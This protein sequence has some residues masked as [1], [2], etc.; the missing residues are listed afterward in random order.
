MSVQQDTLSQIQDSLRGVDTSDLPANA[1]KFFACTQAQV[2]TTTAVAVKAAVTGKRHWIT[3]VRVCNETP[4]EPTAIDIIDTTGTPIVLCSIAAPALTD[5]EFVPPVP[6]PVGAG[7][8][9]QARG[10]LATTGDV[11]VMVAGYVEA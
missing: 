10:S 4:A 3:M 2:T 11:H 6:I 8:A 9:I 7:L 5:N 1:V